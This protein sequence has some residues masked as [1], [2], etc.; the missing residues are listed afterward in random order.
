MR[1]HYRNDGSRHVYFIMILILAFSF[2][3][4]LGSCS[5]SQP[6]RIRLVY[7]N[8]VNYEPLI[9]ATS[10]GFFEDEGL[11]VQVHTVV[12]G[13]VAAEAIA[14]GSADIGAMGDAP[15]II[16]TS[17][18]NE[19]KIIA[20]YGSGEGMHRIISQKDITD[21]MQLTGKKIGLQLGSSTHGAF[22]LWTEK[23]NLDINSLTIVSL[24]P[25]DMPDA[26]YTGQ[27]DAIAGSEPW[28]TN[29]KARC[30]ERVRELSSSEG[31]GNSFP[32]VIVASRKLLISNPDAVKKI[33]RAVRRAVTYIN[34][35]FN[36]SAEIIAKHTGLSP[37]IQKTCMARLIWSV[38]FDSSDLE[39]M[40]KTATFLRDFG[41]IK[42]MPDFHKIIDASFVQE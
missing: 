1:L 7:S 34:E 11:N 5:K 3:W 37:E 32:H 29:V 10:K 22:L 21:P 33:I 42:A 27:I 31:L 35:N 20:R 18:A 4:L 40:N 13:I 38:G 16:V 2:I 19:A 26:M 15:A 12:G 25:F 36:E 41:K 6:D 28:P 17:R 9:L 14:T 8:K 24:H 30:G 23:N 39:S